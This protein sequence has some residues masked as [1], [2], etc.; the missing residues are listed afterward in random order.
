MNKKLIISLEL[1]GACRDFSKDD[2]INFETKKTISISDLRNLIIDYLNDNFQN[3][4]NY[5]N[6]VKKSAFCTETNKVVSD[7]YKITKSQK[8]SII[9]P[10][11]GG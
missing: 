2:L 7:N 1:F 9:P 3:N 5:T 8:I 4:F 11:G 10:I 6:I